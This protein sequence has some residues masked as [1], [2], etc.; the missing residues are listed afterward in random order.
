M[1]LCETDGD[2]P[3][4]YPSCLMELHYDRPDTLDGEISS[5]LMSDLFGD[6]VPENMGLCTRDCAEEHAT[7]DDIE[8]GSPARAWSCQLVGSGVERYPTESAFPFDD[9][10]DPVEMTTGQPFLA[11]CRPSFLSLNNDFSDTCS[12]CETNND[13]EGICWDLLTQTSTDSGGICLT[14]CDTNEECPI[15]F[16]CAAEENAATYCIPLTE[17][18]SD[19]ADIDNDGY[20]LGR[21]HEISPSTSGPT[22]IDCDDRDSDAYYIE[23]RLPLVERCGPELDLNCNGISDEIELVGPSLEFWSEHCSACYDVCDNSLFEGGLVANGA[24]RCV[25]PDGE[26][27]FDWSNAECVAACEI[28]WDD[29]DDNET[30]GCETDLTTIS[31]CG[32][33]NTVCEV[34]ATNYVNSV[35]CGNAQVCSVDTCVNGFADCDQVFTNGCEIYTDFDLTNCG[36][37]GSVCSGTLVNSTEVCAEGS[38]IIG[39]CDLGWDNCDTNQPGC[40][41]NIHD[42]PNN[43]GA[44]DYVCNLDHAV[45]ICDQGGCAIGSCD[46]GWEDCNGIVADGC[47]RSITTPTDCGACDSACN[48]QSGTGAC[49]VEWEGVVGGSPIT[50][51][52]CVIN[53]CNINPMGAGLGYYDCNGEYEDGCEFVPRNCVFDHADGQCSELDPGV[54]GNCVFAEC[55]SGYADCNN[56]SNDCI[57][58]NNCDGCEINTNTSMDHCGGCNE[59][60]NSELIGYGVNATCNTGSCECADGY[61]SQLCNGERT[62]CDEDI[63]QGCPGNIAGLRGTRNISDAEEFDWIYDYSNWASLES[64]IWGCYSTILGGFSSCDGFLTHL[65]IKG[66]DR[67]IVQMIPYQSR[68]IIVTGEPNEENGPVISGSDPVRYNAGEFNSYNLA[69]EPETQGDMIGISDDDYNLNDASNPYTINIGCNANSSGQLGVII[70]FSIS[71]INLFS[72][73][74]SLDGIRPIC[75]NL[76]LVQQ[77]NHYSLQFTGPSYFGNLAGDSDMDHDLIGSNPVVG[78]QA[79][80]KNDSY[81]ENSRDSVFYN[82][83]IVIQTEISYE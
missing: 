81:P 19:C 12:S 60:C 64:Q 25:D 18:C 28:A 9:Q 56:D 69:W 48:V 63:D 39:S 8:T 34:N 76:K 41:R 77:N 72:T 52:E 50:N 1:R 31:T 44:C 79:Q 30:N 33:C 10:L 20:G 80:V 61:S 2:C 17:T 55:H 82:L 67:S 29:C 32:S 13:C 83:K 59:V 58:E 38:C 16:A 37:C 43:C 45:E 40:E 53:S 3:I 5:V 24:A 57:D 36:S 42:D 7:C 51:A 26:G 74:D 75:R 35:M 78:I 4:G 27:D 6:S 68:N 15:G 14:S 22:A 49:D 71:V 23:N 65:T 47:E 46:P 70:G 62:I 21:C 66:D 54:A 11:M 73:R